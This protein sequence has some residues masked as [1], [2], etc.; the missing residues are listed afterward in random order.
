MNGIGDYIRSYYLETKQHVEIHVDAEGRLIISPEIA[1]RL[2]FIPGATIHAEVDGTNLQIRQTIHRLSKIYVEPTSHCNLACRTCIRNVWDE[3]MGHMS[4][5]TFTRIMEGILA[6]PLPRKVFFGGFGEPL[7]HPGIVDM[8]RQAKGIGATVELI[9]NGT[10]LDEKRSRELIAAGL[11]VLWVSFDGATPESYTDV[12]LGAKLPNVLENAERFRSLR[13][14]SHTPSPEI[15]I[16]FVAMERNYHDLP[17]LL[18]LARKLGATRFMV[19][20]VL[21]HT[22]E[23]RR[24]ALYTFAMSNGTYFPSPHQPELYLPKM[25]A[26]RLANAPLYEAICGNWNLNFIGTQSQLTSDRC[27]FV[28]AGATA[29]GWDGGVSPCLPLLHSNH[30]YLNGVERHARRYVVGY[31]NE[32]SLAELWQAPEYVEF[33]A[34]VQGFDFAPCTICDGC[35]LSEKNEEDCYGNGFPTCGGCL[36]AQGFVQCP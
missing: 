2:G 23:M 29:V 33:R 11:D 30:N 21:P 15:G 1:E 28:E 17:D 4:S 25:D 12:R 13:P 34:R 22:A 9:T 35:S 31:I 18:R 16:V 36:W 10:L 7:F 26:A 20:N 14:I 5:V 3:P 19:S 27:P 32:R 24:E 8:V 6:S